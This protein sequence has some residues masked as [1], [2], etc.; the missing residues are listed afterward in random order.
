MQTQIWST[1][2][3]WI[4]WIKFVNLPSWS[5]RRLQTRLGKPAGSNSHKG[6]KCWYLMKTSEKHTFVVIVIT[7]F[8]WNRSCRSHLKQ[9]GRQDLPRT[10]IRP[11]NSQ[12]IYVISCH[13]DNNFPM[14][15]TYSQSLCRLQFVLHFLNKLKFVSYHMTTF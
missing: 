13:G 7:F 9:G 2:K 5:I 10:E 14:K 6:L 3:D 11:K 12:N 1:R 15:K 8:Q 4:G